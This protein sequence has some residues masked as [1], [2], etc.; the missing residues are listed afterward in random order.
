MLLL[1]DATSGPP[2][3]LF[4]RLNVVYPEIGE[5]RGQLKDLA[6]KLIRVTETSHEIQLTK[7]AEIKAETV[8]FR[9]E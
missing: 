7:S 6:R 5:C 9:V 4:A 8:Y 2:S 1:N 3:S